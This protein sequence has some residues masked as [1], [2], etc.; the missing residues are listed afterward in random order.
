MKRTKRLFFITCLLVFVL[1]LTACSQGKQDGKGKNELPENVIH[2]SLSVTSTVNG[3]T[4]S[5]QSLTFNPADGYLPVVFEANAGWASL[6]G[7]HYETATGE[8]YGYDVVG[9]INGSFFSMDTGTLNGNTITDGRITCAHDGF[10][11]EMVTFGAD[12]A[13]RIVN[14]ALEYK[15]SING[16]NYDSALYY[17]NKVS[18]AG[19]VSDKLYYWDSACGTKSDAT[20]AG[21][22]LLF[23]KVDN[24]ELSVGKT[25]VG[26]LVSVTE[27][28]EETMGIEIGSNQFVLYCKTASPFAPSLKSLKPGSQVRIDVNET[29]EESK[30]I[31]ENCSSAITNV[32]WLVKDGV[33]Q[34]ETNKIIGTH[35]VELEARWTAFGTKEDGSYVFFTTE[36]AATGEGGSVTLR[37]VARVMMEMGCTNVIRMDGGGSSAMY[38]CDAGDGN[39][40]F[41]QSSE[42]AVSDCIMVVKRD[43]MNP[44][45]ELKADLEAAIATAKTLYDQTKSEEIKAAYDYA[46]AILDSA[47]A[48]EGEYKKGCAA[49]ANAIYHIEDL[50][51]LIADAEKADK[52]NY[53]DYAYTNLTA[54]IANAKTQ[55]D[56]N[57]SKE[58]LVA[59]YN[60]L[61]YWYMLTGE[62]DI[63]IATGKPYTTNIASHSNYIDT[64]NK[65]LTD[66]LLGDATNTYAAT[67]AGYSEISAAGGTLEVIVDLGETMSGLRNFNVNAHHQPSWG[68]VL[69][70]KITVYV[71]DDGNTWKEVA[72]TTVSAEE[73]DSIYPA[74]VNILATASEDV[75]ARYVKYE[76]TP[77][78]EFIF[79]SEVTAEVHY[80]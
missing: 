45:K 22:E 5:A 47:T 44:S 52:A 68:I 10:T 50:K 79:I 72:A 23:N 6:L 74:A 57:A 4:V 53:T 39:P 60:D 3:N 12:G 30:E 29:V 33:D 15:I 36:G 43:S 56:N 46:S 1:S 16:Q 58:D 48:T 54:V 65:E 2:E 19:S 61:I 21:Y 71:S 37:D 76:L 34:T 70:T 35:S 38:L 75:S 13:M 55:L 8:R 18:P 32:G 42:R 77:T 9:I 40:G 62:I 78:G 73:L 25:L 28:T 80:E 7:D 31:M 49:I 17:I 59:C 20:E 66:G 51:E 69:P 27:T 67:W 14:S 41:V 11:G 26:E 24:T 64:D 63:N